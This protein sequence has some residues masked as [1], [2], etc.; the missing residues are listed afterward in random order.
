[1]SGPR[2]SRGPIARALI[3]APLTL[4]AASGVGCAGSER[5]IAVPRTFFAGSKD[6]KIRCSVNPEHARC[7]IWEHAWDPPSR[8]PRCEGDLSP[9]IELSGEGGRAR[10]VCWEGPRRKPQLYAAHTFLQVAAIKCRFERPGIACTNLE[11][12]DGFFIST[13]G[14]R[15]HL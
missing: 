10:F 11:T 2:R 7:T 8:P 3:A 5:T 9:A 1:M 14:F 6:G 15:L 12:G 4:I 13:E